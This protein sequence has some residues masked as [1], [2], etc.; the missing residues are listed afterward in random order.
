MTLLG[1]L[2]L[3]L[4]NYVGFQLLFPGQKSQKVAYTVFRQEVAKGN[5]ATVHARGA[6]VTGRFRTAVPLPAA[7]IPARDSAAR[8]VTNFSTTVPAFADPGL[9]TLLIQHG[10]EISAAPLEQENVWLSLLF[11]FAPALLIIGLYVWMFRRA[12]GGKIGR[13]H[14]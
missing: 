14:V 4:I 12:Q 10:V 7:R 9:K 5:V 2:M 6:N 3:L 8:T 13:A 11:S 1:F